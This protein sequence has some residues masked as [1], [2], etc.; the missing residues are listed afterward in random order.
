MVDPRIYRA[1]LVLVA[2]AVIVFGFSLQSQPGGV[3][4]T[5]AP[6]QF[7]GSSYGTMTTL[8]KGYANRTP[9]SPSD[10]RLAAYVKSD[11]I[12]NAKG[13]QVSTQEFTA[14]TASGQ[15]VLTDVLASRAGLGSG[16]IVVIAH[17]DARPHAGQAIADMSGTAVLLDLASALSGETLPRSVLLVSTS[18]Q[19]GAAGATASPNRSPVNRWTP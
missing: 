9:G 19:V 18:G 4:T 13:F 15:Q 8:A 16:E 6:G 5:L 12:N 1:L 10:N 3:S 7:F 14:Q 11:L 2:F 17:R